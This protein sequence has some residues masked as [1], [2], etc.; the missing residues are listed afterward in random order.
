VYEQTDTVDLIGSF[1]QMDVSILIKRL[2]EEVQCR[3]SKLTNE[4]L[5]VL[6]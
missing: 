4:S 5:M 3:H 2:V 6:H 1:E